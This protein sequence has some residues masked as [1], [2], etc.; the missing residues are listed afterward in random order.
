LLEAPYLSNQLSAAD[1]LLI[2]LTTSRLHFRW[3]SQVRLLEALVLCEEIL[4]ACYCG[5]AHVGELRIGPHAGEE[6]IPVNCRIGA[7]LS[8]YRELE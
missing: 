7:I 5:Q 1:R 8:L 2:S 4:L 6:R 3:L